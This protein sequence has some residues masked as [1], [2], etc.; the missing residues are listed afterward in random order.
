MTYNPAR[1]AFEARVIFHEAGERITYP[2][3]LAA[4]INSDFETLARGLVLR[5]RAMRARNRGDNIAHLK[6]VAEIAGQSG[7]LSA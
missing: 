1:Q 3:D 5:A 2:V 6:L 4:P 7:R